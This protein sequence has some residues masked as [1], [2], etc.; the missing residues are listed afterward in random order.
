MS[1]DLNKKMR[2][3]LKMGSSVK[4]GLKNLLYI[5]EYLL[6]EGNHILLR[7]RMAS[8]SPGELED[9]VR[10]MHLIK[11]NRDILGA[12]NKGITNIRDL[13]EFSFVESDED[14]ASMKPENIVNEE[15]AIN[16]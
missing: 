6:K 15:A 5:Y 16:G 3:A 9:F 10:L 8:T 1:S 12:L 4:G 2:E 14:E 11:R 13:S 7:E